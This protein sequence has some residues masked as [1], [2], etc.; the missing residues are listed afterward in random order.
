MNP[1]FCQKICALN[2]DAYLNGCVFKWDIIV[3]AYGVELS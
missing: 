2:R 1:D 3:Q